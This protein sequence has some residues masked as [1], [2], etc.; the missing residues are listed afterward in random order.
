MPAHTGDTVGN[1]S[2]M[3]T[4]QTRS[5]GERP[6]RK[7]ERRGTFTDKCCEV[8]I[9]GVGGAEWGW[10]AELPGRGR[11][12]TKAWEGPGSIRSSREPLAGVEGGGG[13][14]QRRVCLKAR[15]FLE[16]EG[17]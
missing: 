3:A 11:A 13:R 14:G 16:C 12:R 15:L 5:R 9:Q 8:K 10:V 2:A 7:K 6:R 1:K 17:R 4:V